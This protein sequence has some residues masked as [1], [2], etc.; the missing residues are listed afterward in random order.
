MQKMKNIK[1]YLTK[2]KNLS[3]SDEKIIFDLRRSKGYSG[4]LEKFNTRW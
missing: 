2:K 1:N 3:E 4:V